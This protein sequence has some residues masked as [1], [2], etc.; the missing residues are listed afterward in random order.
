MIVV[1]DI[2]AKRDPEWRVHPAGPSAPEPFNTIL[3]MAEW[4]LQ[5]EGDDTCV[6]ARLGRDF[7][8]R[9][10]IPKIRD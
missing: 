6:W 2:S 7:I 10:I 1:G 8:G 5:S 9:R 3:A 4:K